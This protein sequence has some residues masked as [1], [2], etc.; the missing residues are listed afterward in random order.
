VEVVVLESPSAVAEEA[1]HRIHD[2]V[3]SDPSPRLGLATGATQQGVYRLLIEA[4]ARGE[5]SF[6]TTRFFM[7]DEYVGVAPTS[8]TSFQN[9]LTTSFLEPIGAKTGSLEVLDGNAPDLSREAERFEKALH[10]AGG[11]GMQ[12]LGIGTNGHIAFNEP[13]SAFDSRT[14]VVELH[15]E[16]VTSNS[17]YFESPHHVPRQ[18][19]SQGLGTIM[20]AR[21]IVL[22]AT[23][24]SKAPAV[25][26]MLDGVISEDCPASLLQRHPHVVVILDSE[27][28]SLSHSR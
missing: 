24:E 10:Q 7:L 22:I 4:Q 1:S 9:V 13:G 26:A 19:I 25:A 12:L 5:I 14:R 15:P 3:H 16:T 27:A 21:S 11:I 20:E 6:A 2:Y 28:A 17:H 8:S 23:G 18:A